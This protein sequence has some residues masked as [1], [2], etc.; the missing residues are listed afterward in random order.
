MDYFDLYRLILEAAKTGQPTSNQELLDELQQIPEFAKY[1]STVSDDKQAQADSIKDIFEVAENLIDDGL[2]RGHVAT[3]KFGP[4]LL[5]IDGLTTMGRQYLTE[6]VK[7]NFKQRL[8]V[9]LLDEGVPLTP[10]AISKFI[11]K[12][13]L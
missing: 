3:V 11:F 13:I 2:V 1:L 9:A 7:P 12:S 4:K 6:L 8:K 10:Q 5:Y